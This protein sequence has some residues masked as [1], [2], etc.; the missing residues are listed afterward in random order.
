[1]ITPFTH[2]S[3]ALNLIRFT[4]TPA[5]ENLE[6]RSSGQLFVSSPSMLP[7]SLANGTTTLQSIV[8]KTS[9]VL[10]MAVTG[11][12]SPV[13]RYSSISN[14]EAAVLARTVKRP[15]VSFAN[16]TRTTS[17]RTPPNLFLPPPPTH[18]SQTSRILSVYYHWCRRQSCETC[19]RVLLLPFSS[20]FPR[21][22]HPTSC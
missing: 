3:N 8:V 2:T 1:M 22:P 20:L 13:P 10:A 21:V 7:Y 4:A 9:H 5:E 6:M 12:S 18:L 14:L 17:S 15:T 16:S 19:L 11:F